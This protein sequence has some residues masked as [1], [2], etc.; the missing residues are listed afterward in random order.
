MPGYQAFDTWMRTRNSRRAFLSTTVRLGAGLAALAALGKSSLKPAGGSA[1][2]SARTKVLIE[3]VTQATP[4]DFS[5]GTVRGG[6]RSGENG[7]TLPPG[8]EFVSGPVHLPFDVTHLGLHW[9]AQGGSPVALAVAVRTHGSGGWSGWEELTVEATSRDEVFAALV[10]GQKRRLAQYRVANTSPEQVELTQMTL[11]TL[12]TDD[13][14]LL[15]TSSTTEPDSVTYQVADGS[16]ITIISRRGWGCDESLRFSGSTERWPEMYVPAKKVVLHHTA[17]SNSYTNGAA[18]V[19]AIYTYHAQT[20]GWGD[21]GYQLLVDRQGNIYEGRHGRGEDASREIA[22]ADVVA[23]HVFGFN[24]GTTGVAAIGNSSQGNWRSAWGA[25]GLKALEDAVTFECGR[26]FIDPSGSSAFLK[27]NGDWSPAISHCPGHGD[28]VSTQCPGSRLINHLPNLRT[29]VAARLNGDPPP[30]LS[31]GETSPNTLEFNWTSGSYLYCLEGWLRKPD[32]EDIDYLHGFNQATTKWNDDL[33]WEQV[34][35]AMSG[36]GISFPDLANGHYTMHLRRNTGT[37]AD[38]YESNLSFWLTG[39]GD[40]DDGGGSEPPPTDNPPSVALTQ[41]E[42]NS[43]VSGQIT[44]VAEATDDNEVTSVEFFVDGASIGTGSNAGNVWSRDWDTTTV[45]D[46]PHTL[47]ATATDSIG[48]TAS[49]EISVSVSNSEPSTGGMHVG[50]LDGASMNQGSTWTAQVTV[51]V[52]DQNHA[53]LSGATVQGAWSNGASGTVNGPT[54]ADGT[55][56]FQVSGIAKRT[57]SVTFSVT[58]ISHAESV[59]EATANHDPDGDSDGT[60]ITILKP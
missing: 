22:S 60:V 13:G 40:G 6:A 7:I 39:A 9:I 21:I 12:N 55:C 24:Y 53:P 10:P 26:H 57:G 33:A 52:H 3:D 56:A 15:T 35:T 20:Q 48:Q 28:C 1:A 47:R 43:T 14:P 34:W 37:L 59:Y 17:T 50:D 4:A 32:S 54:G 11:T 45:S 36:E 30:A 5:P 8:G 16:A 25:V 51:S 38:R 42:A 58:G 29:N 46:G 44:I 27:S 2:H 49:H 18:E 31:G 41:P 19:R 23:G